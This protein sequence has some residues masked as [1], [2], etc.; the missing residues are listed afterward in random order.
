MRAFQLLLMGLIVT[1]GLQERLG[2]H[3]VSA[4]QSS[5]AGKST[6][7]L[8]SDVYPDTLARAPRM[9]KSD[10]TTEEEKQAYDR[11]LAISPTTAEWNVPGAWLGPTGTRILIPE[12]AE[13]Y[14]QQGLTIR[15]KGGLEPRFQELTILVATRECDN[16]NEFLDHAS[17]ENTRKMIS[18]KIVD[19]IRNE[20][21]TMGLDEK[22]ALV[23]RF[24][25]EL[26]HQPKVSSKTFADMQRTFGRKGTLAITL[27]MGYYSTNELVMRVYD[28]QLYRRVG[29]RAPAPPWH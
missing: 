20:K 12:L 16:K 6:D 19:I 1:I 8:P 3:S 11:V 15:K 4:Q 28:Q 5:V 9:K 17:R 14:L 22:D 26:F 13:I 23:I 25:R 29:E 10:F 24:G 21:D 27:L 2:F 7:S 18:P